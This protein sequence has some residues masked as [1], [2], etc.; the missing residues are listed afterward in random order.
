MEEIHIPKPDW[1][2]K[3]EPIDFRVLNEPLEKVLW[4]FDRQLDK[5]MMQ[6]RLYCYVVRMLLK[7]SYQT[8]KAM[9]QLVADDQE[10]KYGCQAHILSRSIVDA[11]FNVALLTEDPN[12]NPRWYR[13]AGY[14]QIWEMYQ[15]ELR[16]YADE[17][18]MMPRLDCWKGVLEEAPKIDELTSEE[19]ANPTSIKYWPT[20]SQMRRIFKGEKK[21][22][23]ER[24]Y[25]ETYGLVSAC[26][27]MAEL[28][29][30][31]SLFS[32]MP[33]AHWNPGKFESDAIMVAMLF[34]L[35]SL[36]EVESVCRFGHEQDLRY[37]WT[38][39]ANY[40]KDARNYYNSRYDALLQA[41]S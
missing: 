32:S 14:R 4:D 19:I 17:P 16:L 6:P 25:A 21:A 30:A 34:L 20:P 2:K 5:E 29:V 12:N 41:G 18:D 10:V 37:V 24:V 33:D 38:L 39:L 40:C 1:V 13:L 8:Y 7:A 31:A 27:H 11:F 22:F 35:M 28:G 23:V 36:S 3:P 9:R 26:S 15:H